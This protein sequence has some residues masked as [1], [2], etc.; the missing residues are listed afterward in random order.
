[1]VSEASR[2]RDAI[3]MS[4]A[5]NG[6]VTVAD[7]S[8]GLHVSPMTVRRDL[9]LLEEQGLIRRV[10]GGALARISNAYEPPYVG[11]SGKQSEAKQ[12]IAKAALDLVIDGDTIVLDTGTTCLELARALKGRKV[13]TV[14]TAALRAAMELAN[15]PDIRVVVAGGFLRAGELSLVGA[16]AENVF[17]EFNCDT[18]F[19]GVGGVHLSKGITDFNPDDARIKRLAVTTAARKVV[20]ADASKLGRAAFVNVA[21]VDEIDVLITDASKDHVAVQALIDL[22]VS[23]ITV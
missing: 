15:E 1:V 22:G 14:V 2:R 7:L 4:V 6:Q 9:E 10:R 3:A 23:V 17:H 20:L 12:R 8:D 18:A 13:I 5:Q 19:V 11:R 21:R 16:L